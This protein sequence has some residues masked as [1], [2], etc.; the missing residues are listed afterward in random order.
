MGLC[1]R[2]QTLNTTDNHFVAVE[3]D[4]YS[5]TWDPPI[6]HVGIDINSMQSV[7]NVSWLRANIS[8][9]EG[10]ANE[11][12]ITYNSTSHNLSVLFTGLINNATVFE[13]SP[14]LRGNFW[15]LSS[16]RVCYCNSYHSH[17]GF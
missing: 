10:R 14:T 12:W 17:M 16:N 5:N 3:F 6:A 8:I 1:R 7:A 4:P 13:R 15:I 9:T 11:A 2:N